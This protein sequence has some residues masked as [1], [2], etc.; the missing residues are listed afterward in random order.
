MRMRILLILTA[1]LISACGAGPEVRRSG[2]GGVTDGPWTLELLGGRSV[3][4]MSEHLPV[5][6]FSSEGLIAGSDGCNRLQGSYQREDERLSFSRFAS[7]RMGCAHGE[8]LAQAF[9]AALSIVQSF[10]VA[11]DALSLYDGTGAEV[12]RLRR[13]RD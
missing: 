6:S 3:D 9:V 4:Q 11:G 13:G 2:D 10:E 12:M 1:V 5:L 7:T 8:A